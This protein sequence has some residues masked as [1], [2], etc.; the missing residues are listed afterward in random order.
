[1]P[2]IPEKVKIQLHEQTL[3]NSTFKSQKGN[4]RGASGRAVSLGTRG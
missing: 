4:V 3:K 1:M 2:A